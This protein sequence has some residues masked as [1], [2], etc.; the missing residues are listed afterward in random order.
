M[1]LF[2]LAYQA[3]ITVCAQSEVVLKFVGENAWNS[4]QVLVCLEAYVR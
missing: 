3:L 1:P 2:S 4:L